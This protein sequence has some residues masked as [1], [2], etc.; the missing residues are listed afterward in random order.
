[1]VVLVDM[2]ARVVA[3]AARHQQD[4]VPVLVV[5]RLLYMARVVVVLAYMD[6][7]PTELVHQVPAHL[8]L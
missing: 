5:V 7:V 8:E 6:K 3:V 4:R 2:A 1:M